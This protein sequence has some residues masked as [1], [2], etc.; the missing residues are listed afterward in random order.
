MPTIKLTD[1]LGLDEDITLADRS[2]LRQYFQQLPSLRLNNLDLAKLGGL[3]LDQ[4]ALTSLSTGVSF[5]KPIPIGAGSPDLSVS[6]GAH[7][8]FAIIKRVPGTTSLPDVSADDVDLPADSCYV[9]FGIDASVGANVG[10][11]A[12]SLTFGVAP[13]STITIVNYRTFPLHQGVTL[14]DAL[15][16]TVGGF[17]IPAGVDDLNALPQGAL[18]TVTG[19]GSLTLSVTANLLAIANPLAS[20]TLPGPLPALAVSAGGTAT[21]N[22]SYEISCSYQICARKLDSGKVRLG[23]YREQSSEIQVGATVSANVSA[24]LGSTDLFSTIVV[25]ISADPAADLNELAQAKL[26]DDEIAAIRDA[27]KAAVQRKLE[28]ALSAQ[29]SATQSEDASFSYEIDLAALTPD[30]RKALEQALRGDLSS[31]H[32]SSLPGIS[33]MSS[34]WEKARTTGI[35]FHVNLLGI[36][37]V[38]SIATLTKSGRV[39]YEPA[40]GA[41][42]I[43]DQLSAARI[44]STQVNFGADTQKLRKVMSESFLITVAYSGAQRKTG[45]PA[46][47][48]S[49]SYFDLENQ[50]GV[51][52]MLHM[53][54]T[55]LA[56]GLFSLQESAAP[57][58]IQDFG[59]TMVHA[60][61]EYD[62]AL[63]TVVFLD[64]NGT[65][66]T[67]PF[68]EQM[69]RNALQ[70]LVSDT[71]QDAVRRKPAI[72]DA[73]WAQMRA[74]GQPG[75]ASLF[76][77]VPPSFVAAITADYSAIVWWADAMTGA[78]QR[79]AKIRQWLDANPA[80]SVDDAT[81]QSLRAD[82]ADHL[83]RVVADTR[84][85]FGKPWG[86]LAM[87]EAAAHKPGATILVVGPR[88][89]RSKERLLAAVSKP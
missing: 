40:T 32:A 46:L 3:T 85:E 17:V 31:L 43:T 7:A 29:L 76:P 41:L 74:Q 69:G 14:L 10:A 36:L 84:E 19:T 87:N 51:P 64:P 39:L 15:Q 80:A 88:L 28:L 30:S 52:Q 70:Y 55:G 6:A 72:D 44:Q 20:V 23:W 42:V 59:R 18:T 24:S 5:D 82:L 26:S 77:A 22:A 78:A 81:F 68:Y 9:S 65:P 33:C 37:N 73:L 57:P 89:V 21:V 2:A 38:G 47:R 27:V 86:L 45:G 67:H 34:A 63:A 62:D 56:L 60:T 58:G 16:G 13:S 12:G 83:K 53:L 71:D 48:F 79:L 1:A 49:H 66:L 75:I 35:S 11:G 25:K 61:T 50:T 8:S 54:R 4:P